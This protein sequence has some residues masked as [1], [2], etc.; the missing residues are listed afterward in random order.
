MGHHTNWTSCTMECQLAGRKSPERCSSAIGRTN[1]R[2]SCGRLERVCT[3]KLISD[4]VKPCIWS[5]LHHCEVHTHGTANAQHIGICTSLYVR[6]HVQE[7][8]I[9]LLRL[10]D[11][12]FVPPAKFCLP[13]LLRRSCFFIVNVPELKE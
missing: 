9:K 5:Q 3:N 12:K 7:C 13:S 4:D 10:Y 6:T 8:S 2:S 11:L 1:T